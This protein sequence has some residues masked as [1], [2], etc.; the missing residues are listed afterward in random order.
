MPHYIDDNKSSSSKKKKTGEDVMAVKSMKE[1]F[2][3]LAQTAKT[4][5]DYGNIGVF[6]REGRT[7]YIPR[8][9]AGEM[10]DARR[11]MLESI[12]N[13]ETPRINQ[14]AP[15]VYKDPAVIEG[16]PTP[17]QI[18]GD[19]RM[20]ENVRYYDGSIF[21][22]PYTPLP[23]APEYYL[24]GGQGMANRAVPVVGPDGQVVGQLESRNPDQMDLPIPLGK[25]D[26][27]RNFINSLLRR[28]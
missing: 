7:S 21:D 25:V 8:Q 2:D 24:P 15:P 16:Y 22:Q 27:Y 23:G 1:M 14:P 9:V 20:L 19:P 18:H 12:Y 5:Y 6:D 26:E 17:E 4:Q 10:E 28:R 13:P 3:N 11:Q